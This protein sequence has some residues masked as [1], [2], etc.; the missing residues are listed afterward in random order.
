MWELM[1]YLIY[2]KHYIKLQ[3][4][5]HFS[6]CPIKSKPLLWLD[7]SLW[8]YWPRDQSVAVRSQCL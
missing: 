3:L 8:F 6:D 2:F 1:A 7:V 5:M 4:H